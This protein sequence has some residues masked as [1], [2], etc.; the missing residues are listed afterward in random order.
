[1]DGY[2]TEQK[3]WT[4]ADDPTAHGRLETVLYNAAE[5]LRII[6]ALAHPCLPNATEK[7]WA[8]L[9]QPGKLADQRIDQLTQG[10]CGSGRASGNWRRHFRASN[11]KKHLEKIMTLEGEMTQ[12]QGEKAAAAGHPAAALGAVAAAAGGPAA[13]GAAAGAG[14]AL[15]DGWRRGPAGGGAHRD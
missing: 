15:S 12:P 6:V 3:P 7:I 1:M 5:A 13:A 9:G 14:A 2:L 10:A 8:Q 11:I 4:L